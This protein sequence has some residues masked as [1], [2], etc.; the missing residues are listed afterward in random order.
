[1]RFHLKEADT[2]AEQEKYPVGRHPLARNLAPKPLFQLPLRETFHS[3]VLSALRH[4]QERIRD[5]SL[6]QA[7]DVFTS[8]CYY[9]N[10]ASLEMWVDGSDLYRAVCVVLRSPYPT[11]V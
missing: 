1:M 6:R 11:H 10:P 7:R 3:T 5:T 8:G 2:E 9:L 4:H